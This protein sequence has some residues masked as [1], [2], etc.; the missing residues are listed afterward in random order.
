MAAYW[1]TL[2]KEQFLSFQ[3][4]VVPNANFSGNFVDEVRLDLSFSCLIKG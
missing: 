3:G 2:E 1:K 4:K